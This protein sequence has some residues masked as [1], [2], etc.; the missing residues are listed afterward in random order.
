MKINLEKAKELLIQG[1]VVA[2]PT[3]TVYGL[4]AIANN[5]Q[6]VQQIFSLKGRPAHNPL[7][8]HIGNPEECLQYVA[9]KPKGLESLISAFW[10]GPLTV[11]VPV[12]QKAI[13]PAVRANLPSAAFR[14]P[15]QS[16]TLQLLQHVSPLVAPSANLSGSPSATKLEHVEHDF[17]VDF[18]VLDGG[19][20]QHGVE[21]TIVIA[22]QDMWQ[23]ARLGAVSQEQLAET[24]GYLPLLCKANS[25]TP[26]CPGQLLAHYAPK[27]HLVLSDVPFVDCPKKLSVVVGFANRHYPGAER[28]F[29]LTETE[30]ATVA[31]HRL[32]H[33]LRQLDVENIQAAWVDMQF[34]VDGLWKT[35]SER[36]SRAANQ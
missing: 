27:A 36:L 35:V 22:H 19:M 9:S 6:A 10:P 17:G 16:Q 24:L 18:P 13:L 1:G 21:S 5:E 20:C 8:L 34:P 23:V 26:V 7:I 25:D 3:E 11:V 2:I 30:D 32:Y 15:K 12:K 33:V 31:A 14:M 28:I 29:S 4:A